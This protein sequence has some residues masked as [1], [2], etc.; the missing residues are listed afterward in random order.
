MDGTPRKFPHDVGAPQAAHGFDP[1]A[2]ASLVTS[3]FAVAAVEAVSE[4]CAVRLTVKWPNDLVVVADDLEGPGYRK[5]AG[6][7]TE[8]VVSDGDITA[9]VVG[10]GMNTSWGSMPPDLTDRAVS[11]D[12]LAGRAVSRPMLLSGLLRHFDANY[13]C[14]LAAGGRGAILE[15]TQTVSATIGNRVSVDLGGGDI[16]MGMA[17]G[18]GSGGEL[19]VRD[20]DG[21]RHTVSA[22]EVIRLR[23]APAV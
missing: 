18:L 23:P 4:L 14:L 9:L 20:G 17:S 7:L 16:L 21:R 22:G 6:I 1:A 3:A 2:E 5:V 13:R 8:S 19:I 11:L 15:R 12:Q 10:M